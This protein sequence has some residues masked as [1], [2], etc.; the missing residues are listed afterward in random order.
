MKLQLQDIA[1]WIGADLRAREGDPAEQP[2]TGYSIDT[3]TLAPGDLFFAIRGERYDAH[4]FVAAA[5]ERGARAAVVSRSKV[6]D[7]L[8]LAHTNALL[9]VD[10]SIVALQ[11][12]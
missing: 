2:A 4:D 11:I 5:L 6:V 9:I 10:D 8:N 12:L 1:H 3:R 7:L